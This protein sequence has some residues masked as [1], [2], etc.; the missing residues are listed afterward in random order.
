MA[1]KSKPSP[2]IGIAILVVIALAVGAY[3]WWH[4]KHGGVGTPTK[5]VETANTDAAPVVAIDHVDP[6]NE[7]KKVTLRGPLDV[8][9]P[10]ADYQL[11][12]R[13]EGMML[14]RYADMLQWQEKKTGDKVD[15]VQVW[16]P[17]PIDSSK[18]RE[19][20]AHRNPGKMPF[21]IARFSSTDIRLGAFRVDG[22]VLGNPR[23]PASLRIEPLPHPVKASELPSNLA[24]SFRDNDG[25]LYS[26]DPANRA[27]G[28]MRVIYRVIPAAT[29]EI[30]GIQRGD[31]IA[32]EKSVVVDSH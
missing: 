31:R 17:Q 11:G 29:V 10:P 21:G 19:A 32:P 18:F 25:T 16:S 24:V 5:P 28:D 4:G 30:T 7:G 6:A 22:G 8:R 9:T 12:I 14:L 3:V 20:D 13:G 15:Y 23:N 26:G 1:K 2:A 27:I